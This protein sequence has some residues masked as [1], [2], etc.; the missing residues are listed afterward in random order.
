MKVFH[1]R[2][3]GL[4]RA[5]LAAALLLLA[6]AATASAKG[7][8]LTHV[9]YGPGVEEYMR[10][11]PAPKPN[12]TTVV[13]V[14][15]GGWHIQN[16]ANSALGLNTQAE[17]LRAH[18]YAIFNL[19][20]PQDTTTTAFPLETKAVEA[21]TA[22]AQEHAAE[23]SANPAKVVLIGGSAGG[24]LVERVAESIHPAGVVSLSGPTDF[25]TIVEAIHN[26]TYK[27]SKFISSVG[28]AL[29]CEP[30]KG[31]CSE[32]YMKEWSPVDNVPTT[33][34]PRWQLWSAEE[35]LVPISQDHEMQ[36]A[37]ETAGCTSNL[38][39]IPGKGHA[40]SYWNSA[41]LKIFSFI[42]SI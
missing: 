42:A 35:D 21:A 31:V 22:F 27:E 2:A 36:T 14:H 33:A 12:G 8:I 5:V 37:L 11:Y 39:V 15:G 34:C 3:A 20:Y 40:F 18:G 9:N 38:E 41:R 10:V 29:G 16:G 28:K 1:L 25:V 17:G 30:R 19:E 7:P 26:G 23:Y 24:Q 32:T 4:G 6:S 13:L